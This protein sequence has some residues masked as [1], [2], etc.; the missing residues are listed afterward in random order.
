MGQGGGFDLLVLVPMKAVFAL[1][2]ASCVWAAAPSFTLEQIMA[3][4]FAS[5][6]TAG[7][8]GRL[9]WLVNVRGA[10][11]IW[12]AGGPD[13]HARQITKFKGDDGQ[14]I[15]LIGWMPDGAGVVFVRGGDLE[16]PRGE[17]PNPLSAPLGVE[18]AVWFAPV[19]GNARKLA[20]GSSP[21]PIPGLGRIV[22][23][24]GNQLWSVTL[25]SEDKPVMLAQPRGGTSSIVAAPDGSAVAFV[26]TRQ[27]HSFIGVYQFTGKSLRYLDASVDSD[28]LPAWSPDSRSVGF[29][30]IAAQSRRRMS[31]PDRSAADPWSIR[32]ADVQTG[33]GRE[34]WKAQAGPGSAFHPIAT[35]SL[36]WAGG[37]LVFPW[38]RD[39]WAHLYSV[40]AGGGD[41]ALLTPGEFEVEHAALSA[42]EREVLYS[43]NQDDIDRRHIWRVETTPGARPAP[44]TRGQGIEWAPVSIPGGVAY[45]R[46]DARMP[47]RAAVQTG[48]G[49]ARD[50]APETVPLDFPAAAL[51][52]PQPVVFTAADGMPIHGQLFLPPNASAGKKPAII[53]LHGGSRRQMLLGWHSMYYYNNAYAMNQYLAASGY[54]VLSVNYRSGI[55]YGLNFREAIGYGPA[56]ASEY[57]DVI[58]AGLYLRNRA[59]VDARRIGLWGG[60]YGG[61]LT[62][63]GLARASELFAAGVDLHGVHDW[64]RLRPFETGSPEA[65]TA[66][67]S[68]PMASVKTW[69]SPVLLIHGDDDRNVSFSES[70]RLVQ[71]LREQKV[72]FELL[73]FPDEIHDFLTHAHWVE[74][75]RASAGF[76]ARKLK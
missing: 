67:E 3:K 74:A 50:L 62:A 49:A 40:S 26:S 69:K 75:Y 32:V 15:G 30:R 5:E 61:Y 21:T 16:N 64:S 9:A 2:A 68:S 46:A 34:V 33:R 14:E 42:D 47:A 36:L 29:V 37:R 48:S 38:E 59:D 55:G 23:T 6:L 18:Q 25:A 73:I 45:I 63:L 56:G 24:R 70:V 43:S 54:V 10:R 11:N 7:P 39:G 41:A 35:Y 19:D 28:M 53:F 1:V 60:S 65:R 17:F 58:G 66:F 72:E 51:V 57:N 8:E 22:F 12:M 52:E 31:N 4:P 71:A 13:Y 27:D 20:N 44:V 76:L